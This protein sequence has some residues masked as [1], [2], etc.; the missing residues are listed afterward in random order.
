MTAEPFDV[1]RL[2][3]TQY[4][5]VEVLAARKRLGENAW[6]FPTRLRLSNFDQLGAHGLI[7]WKF[8]TIPG[9]VLAWFTGYGV[10]SCLSSTYRPPR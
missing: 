8:A 1:D 10:Q 3:P 5:I 7:E 9:H 6:T 4:L 2:T